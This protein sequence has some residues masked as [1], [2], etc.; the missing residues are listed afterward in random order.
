MSISPIAL[1]TYECKLSLIVASDLEQ[2]N[3]YQIRRISLKVRIFGQS[4]VEF[5]LSFHSILGRDKGDIL[6]HFL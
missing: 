2:G 4:E 5:W 3:V 6:M 1:K